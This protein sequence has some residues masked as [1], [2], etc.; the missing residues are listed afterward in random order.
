MTFFQRL[1]VYLIGFGLGIVLTFF[2]FRNRGCEWTPGNRVLAQIGSSEIL[3]SDSIKCVLK[4]NGYDEDIIFET[5]KKG[6][7]NFGESKT[8][9][10]PKFYLIESEEG[11]IKLGFIVK[12]DSVNLLSEIRGVKKGK[13]E[14]NV[15]RILSMPER[16]I[17]KILNANEIGASDSLLTLIKNAGIADGE[18]YNMIKKSKINF[19]KSMPNSKPHPL[20]YVSFKKFY[21]TLEITEEKTRVLEFS[22]R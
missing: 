19:Q 17:R 8:H 22:V 2:L 7:V 11:K 21:F 12:N 10:E 16:T 4:E 6:E 18:L 15:E 1:R 14:G 5:L 20:Y 9:E 13:C 3:L